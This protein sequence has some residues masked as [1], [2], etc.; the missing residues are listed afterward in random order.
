MLLI[1]HIMLASERGRDIFTSNG[2][3]RREEKSHKHWSLFIMPLSLIIA[4]FF[5]FIRLNEEQLYV[6]NSLKIREK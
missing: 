3:Y 4:F 2:D 6:L 5:L 1:A